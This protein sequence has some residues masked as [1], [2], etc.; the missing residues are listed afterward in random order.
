MTHVPSSPVP[1]DGSSSSPT[2]DQARTVPEAGT[3][4][5]A[6]TLVPALV[7][8]RQAAGS[9]RVAVRGGEAA[10]AQDYDVDVVVGGAGPRLRVHTVVAGAPAEL[11]VVDGLVY[12]RTAA[13]SGDAFLRIDP[14]DPQDP[15]AVAFA[16]V[17]SME[18]FADVAALHGAIVDVSA[19]DV[20]GGSG[21]PAGVR[22]SVT[23]DTSLLTG[24]RAVQLA[25]LGSAAPATLRYLLDVDAADRLRRVEVEALGSTVVMDVDRWGDVDDV[26]APGDDELTT[27]PGR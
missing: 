22:Y 12:L 23:V 10:G 26:L 4:L 6:E 2:D 21:A 8:A 5:G 18:P 27:L 15:L 16:G 14:Q 17:A 24:P 9:Y 13:L 19:A 7:Q 25:M 1:P 20:P 3:L 11:R